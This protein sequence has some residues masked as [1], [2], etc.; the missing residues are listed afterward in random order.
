[1]DKNELYGLIEN[2]D[3]IDVAARDSLLAIYNSYPYF[4]AV[5]LLLLKALHDTNSP[6]YEMFLKKLVISLP[7]R[8]KAFAFINGLEKKPSYKE[9]DMDINGLI[10]PKET[11]YEDKEEM[12][13]DEWLKKLSV[14]HTKQ[15]PEEDPIS[16]F[17][18]KTSKFKPSAPTPLNTAPQPEPNGHTEEE[19]NLFSETLAKIYAKQGHIDKAIKVYEKLMLHFPKKSSY[20]ASQIEELR[21]LKN[22]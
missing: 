20:F 13:F 9:Q 16:K 17:L 15:H 14:T 6:E 19:E 11:N 1:M 7:D 10:E 21:K 5:Q 3:S 12:S 22:K 8:P 4:H 2:A 18:K